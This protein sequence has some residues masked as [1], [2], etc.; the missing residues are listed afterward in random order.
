M[1]KQE[2]NNNEKKE[3]R[4]VSSPV[5]IRED[6]EKRLVEGYAALF[7]TPS[8]R[9]SFEERIEEGA[10]DGVI[11]TSDVLALLNHSTSRGIL[12]R[13]RKGVGSL[14]LSIDKKGL[15]Y[16]FE[17]PKTAL[18]DELLEGIRRGDI[19]ESS[20]AF[21]VKDDKWEKDK[22]R[23]IWKRSIIRVDELFDVSPVYT[24]AYSQ[25]SVYTRGLEDAEKQLEEEE[26]RAKGMPDSYFEELEKK[27]KL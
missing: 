20:F 11:E 18:G 10:F 4:M 6:G 24:A 14:T 15:K 9:L 17:A 3:I 16:S 5:E 26:R 27:Y 25:T 7:D 1:A 2:N 8:D 21:T 12:A 23:G 22:E 13:A 19:N